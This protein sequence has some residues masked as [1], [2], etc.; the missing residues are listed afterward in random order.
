MDLARFGF[1]PTEAKVYLAL[2]PIS[3]ATGYAVAQSA[4]L[5]R[6]NTYDALDGLAARAIVTRLPGRPARFAALDPDALIGRLR[7]DLSSGL[8]SL[9]QT[10]SQI[11]RV[12]PGPGLPAVESI[13]DRAVL[14]ERAQAC[15]RDARTELLAVVGPWASE[16]YTALEACGSGVSARVLSLGR[17]A[18]AGAA[19]REVPPADIEGYWGGLP[20]A[21]VADRRRAVCGVVVGASEAA[22]IATEHPG[23]IPF[24]RHLLR[25]EL[26]SAS[27][28]QV[29]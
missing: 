17:P 22:G 16:T 26:A 24:V 8:D 14:L 15:V 20:V 25:R 12:Q 5:A 2:L 6:A 9:A 13:G 11:P 3:P 21:L 29:S 23:V 28:Q 4:K 19:V 1:T 27:P 10:L 18:P 7:R